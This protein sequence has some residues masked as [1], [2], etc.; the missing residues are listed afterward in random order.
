MLEKVR[1]EEVLQDEELLVEGVLGFGS[2]GLFDGLL[3]H[4]H[5]LPLFELLEEAEFLDVI[6]RV[7]LDQPLP[8]RDELNGG[9]VLVQ[10]QTL[11]RESV[12]FG[13]VTVVVRDNLKVVGVTILQVGVQVHEDCLLF[14]LA[15]K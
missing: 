1:A 3:P 8:K 14:T 9:V 6:V 2:V 12:V 7:T 13:N 4:A 10:G 15:I 5:E 11:T